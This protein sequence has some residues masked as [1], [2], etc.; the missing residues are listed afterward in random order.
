MYIYMPLT[1]IKRRKEIYT[2]QTYIYVAFLDKYADN[3]ALMCT[4]GQ[5]STFKTTLQ[6]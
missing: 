1:S 5:E 2:P 3:N 6:L 4:T